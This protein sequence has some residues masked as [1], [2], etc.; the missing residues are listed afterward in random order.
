MALKIMAKL[1]LDGK[2]FKAGAEQAKQAAGKM[3]RHIVGEFKATGAQF[4]G[5]FAS[6]YIQEQIRETADYAA[7]VR[8]LANTYG[9]STEHIQKLGFASTQSGI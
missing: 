8:D 5:M 7:Q 9:M 3:K 4:A 2:G 1:G 6:S